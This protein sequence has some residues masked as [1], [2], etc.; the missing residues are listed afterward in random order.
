MNLVVVQY[1]YIFILICKSWHSLSFYM[2]LETQYI[3][4][5]TIHVCICSMTVHSEPCTVGN[6]TCKE[7]LCVCVCVC[8]DSLPLCAMYMNNHV[9]RA[10]FSDIER[11]KEVAK[12]K[13]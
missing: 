6:E 8:M 2:L 13:E 7:Q 4:T 10:P 11:K 9:H 3:S 5:S 1:K 12:S